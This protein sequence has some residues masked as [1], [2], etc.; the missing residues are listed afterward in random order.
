MESNISVKLSL[1]NF[2][3]KYKSTL[4]KFLV[5]L[6]LITIEEIQQ[7]SDFLASKGIKIAR[8]SQLKVFLS[9][10]DYVVS[11]VNAYEQSGD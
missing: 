2:D 9:G 10:Y 4:D 3:E 8:P 6:G 5:T 7:I 11:T 1:F